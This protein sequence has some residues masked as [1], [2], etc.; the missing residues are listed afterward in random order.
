VYLSFLET[1]V[2]CS[3]VL[4]FSTFT[5]PLLTSFFALCIFAAGSMSGDLRVF[6][7]KFGGEGT[8]LVTDALYYLLPNLKVFNLRHEAVHGLPFEAGDI[9]RATIYAAVYSCVALFF[10][11]AVF[12]RREFK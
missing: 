11:C 6:A 2:V 1:A 7:S 5:T 12:K 3:L 10:A 9:L 8:K 4:L